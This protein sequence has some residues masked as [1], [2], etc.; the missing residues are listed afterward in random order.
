VNIFIDDQ[1]TADLNAIGRNCSSFLD[2]A[3]GGLSNEFH[4]APIPRRIIAERHL[5]DATHGVPPRRHRHRP[6]LH[7]ARYDDLAATHHGTQR[8]RDI[9]HDAGPGNDEQ[10]HHNALGS[11]GQQIQSPLHGSSPRAHRTAR[12]VLPP[13]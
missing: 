11:H 13:G 7:Q 8:G 6:T 9:A 1:A 4:Y 3:F 2:T 12:N 10:G 5:S